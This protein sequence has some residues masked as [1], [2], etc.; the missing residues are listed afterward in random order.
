MDILTFAAFNDVM[1]DVDLH[2]VEL[3]CR[4]FS[5]VFGPMGEDVDTV[6]INISRPSFVRPKFAEAV[7]AIVNRHDVSL[8]KLVLEV[9]ED[10]ANTKKSRQWQR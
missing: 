10:V 5:R 6:T 8:D 3:V 9:I 7:I 1:Q 4:N 2:V